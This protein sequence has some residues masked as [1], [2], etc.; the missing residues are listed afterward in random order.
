M[1]SCLRALLGLTSLSFLLLAGCVDPT[2]PSNLESTKNAAP[3]FAEGQR[4]E[5]ALRVGETRIER[6]GYSHNFQ[7]VRAY[8]R[9]GSFDLAVDEI[10]ELTAVRVAKAE[11]DAKLRAGN[12]DD[13][14]SWDKPEEEESIEVDDPALMAL[15]QGVLYMNIGDVESAEER[16]AA[17]E[18]ALIQREEDSSKVGDFFSSMFSVVGE[19]I[20]G[21][22]ELDSYS[23]EP[24]EELLMLN[25][26]SLTHLLQGQRK[27]YNVARRAA[28]RQNE[29]REEF[30]EE[31]KDSGNQQ[32][33]F[34]RRR[35]RNDGNDLFVVEGWLQ[36]IVGRYS[37]VAE[38][39]PSAY[40][41]PLGFYVVGMINEIESYADP[42]LRDNA[43]IAYGKALELNPQSPVLK[44]A[45]QAMAQRFARD[46]HKV[47]HVLA[48]VGL[49]PEKRVATYGFLADK[50]YGT[51]LPLKFPIYE[52]TADR[53]ARIEV[54]DITGRRLYGELSSVADIEAIALRY[55][56]DR[57]PI[58]TVRFILGLYP[59]LMERSIWSGL[60]QLGEKIAAY[61]DASINPDMRSWS[62]LPGHVSALRLVVPEGTSQL[63]VITYDR[64]GTRLASQRVTLDQVA[65][66]FVYARA[67]NNGLSA[68][69]GHAAWLEGS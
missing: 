10:T 6:A 67:I 25:F 20:A 3:Q 16:F 62:T 47:V 14:T 45:V 8:L 53:V 41:N 27:A 56:K 13:D 52:P 2:A 4:S 54:R 39:V 34:E 36:E 42:S 29:Q 12:D 46:D 11:A 32:K 5:E 35:Q 43:R 26:K 19:A 49:A 61:R 65:H 18:E 24:F 9:V 40:V 37:N 57:L 50:E 1:S 30:F 22:G 38:R 15:E 59:R 33:E 51:I 17:A 21:S 64:A 68:I 55:Q 7:S 31:L 23:P 69:T 58:E 63:Q 66:S 60:G 48:G 44:E 28:D